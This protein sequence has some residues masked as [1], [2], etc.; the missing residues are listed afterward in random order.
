MF[1]NRLRLLR[2]ERGLT[3]R[4]MAD[5]LGLTERNYQRYKS[6]GPMPRYKMLLELADYFG[7]SLDYLFGRTEKRELNL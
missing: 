3:Q 4:R 6:D 5:M 1:N 2:T 7:V